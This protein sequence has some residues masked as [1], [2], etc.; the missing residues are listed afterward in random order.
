[1]RFC[2]MGDGTEVRIAPGHIENEIHVQPQPVALH[3]EYNRRF[4]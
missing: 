3:L 1:M 2:S 4:G